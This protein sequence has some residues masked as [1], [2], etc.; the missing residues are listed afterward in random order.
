[1][2]HAVEL[3]AEVVVQAAGVVLLDDEGELAA[4]RRRRTARLRRPREVAFVPVFAQAHREV[5][6]RVAAGDR[7]ECAE[8]VRALTAGRERRAAVRRP[9]LSE[10]GP[11]SSTLCFNS[12]IKSTTGASGRCL[13]SGGNSSAPFF[14]L[15]R[16]SFT[17]SSR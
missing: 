1:L 7:V 8:R 9:R 14:A 4:A 11:D 12:A 6:R 10:R 13:G 5:R 2:E 16:R 15:L 17:R 3:E